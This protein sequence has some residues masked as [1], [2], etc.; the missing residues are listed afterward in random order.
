MSTMQIFE[1]VVILSTC[2]TIPNTNG[3]VLVPE[4]VGT[5]LSLIYSMFPPIKV[6]KD[7]RFGFGF[8]L[9]PNIDFQTIVELGPQTNTQPLGEPTNKRAANSKKTGD[10]KLKPMTIKH[11]F[12]Q[13][14]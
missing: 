4:E 7:S 1:V 12:K 10:T 11:F 14:N 9:G 13:E 3:A 5:L 2:L 6:G 8:R